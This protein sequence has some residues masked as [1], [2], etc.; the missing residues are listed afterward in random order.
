MNGK[1]GRKEY[2]LMMQTDLFP[3]IK[4]V[5][6][7]KKKKKKLVGQINKETSLFVIL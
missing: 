6:H 2:I 5:I 7:V 4:T 1:R 3:L